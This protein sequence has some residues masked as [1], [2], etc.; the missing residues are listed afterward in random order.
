MLRLWSSVLCCS[1]RSVFIIGRVKIYEHYATF[2]SSIPWHCSKPPWIVSKRR[3]LYW[4]RISTTEHNIDEC[5]WL[6]V[7]DK[8]S[9]KQARRL[10]R[11][12]VTSSAWHLTS[13]Y[14]SSS[15][16]KRVPFCRE[17]I[18]PSRRVYFIMVGHLIVYQGLLSHHV[19]KFYRI[20]GTF[21]CWLWRSSQ[22]S[23]WIFR[24]R[25]LQ[26]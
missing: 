16:H 24:S 26:L 21:V 25:L 11:V 18:F 20:C 8:L 14:W 23:N 6:I 10:L 22:S 1:T 7:G 13:W 17:I 2:P 19:S 12:C 5:R 9:R 4:G 15:C 3:K